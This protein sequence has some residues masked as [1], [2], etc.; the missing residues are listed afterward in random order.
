MFTKTYDSAYDLYQAFDLFVPW[1][2]F[3]YARPGEIKAH[4]EPWCKRAW[5][6]VYSRRLERQLSHINSF[7]GDYV[8]Y[9]FAGNFIVHDTLDFKSFPALTLDG[10]SLSLNGKWDTLTR[11]LEEGDILEVEGLSSQCYA[12]VTESDGSLYP[13]YFSCIKELTEYREENYEC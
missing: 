12:L 3:F 8:A 2:V 5:P 13:K 9:G 4:R 1:D 10:H 6:K 11:T 7:V